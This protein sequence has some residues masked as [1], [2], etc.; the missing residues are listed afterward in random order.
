MQHI[1]V[2]YAEYGSCEK[3]GFYRASLIIVS[4]I[5]QSILGKKVS[6][7]GL[8]E[9]SFSDQISIVINEQVEWHSKNYWK[10]LKMNTEPIHKA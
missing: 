4:Y 3:N 2:F 1:L 8:I 9:L 7:N 5:E 10:Q 6:G